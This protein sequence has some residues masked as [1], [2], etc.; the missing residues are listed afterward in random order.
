MSG[1]FDN[2]VATFNHLGAGGDRLGDDA[3]TGAVRRGIPSWFGT[4]DPIRGD[5]DRAHAGGWSDFDDFGACND[6]GVSPVDDAATW[7]IISGYQAPSQIVEYILEGYAFD[8][9]AF[10]SPWRS[11]SEEIYSHLTFC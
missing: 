6:L 11:L 2:A 10:I 8:D 5:G 3:S 1:G 4:D 7:R 9:S